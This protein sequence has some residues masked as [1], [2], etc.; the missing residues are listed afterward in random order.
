MNRRDLLK[1]IAASAASPYVAG[2]AKATPGLDQLSV[3]PVHAF[4][5]RPLKLSPGS[6]TSDRLF[7]VSGFGDVSASRL[8]RL[9]AWAEEAPDAECHVVKMYNQAG[10]GFD[11]RMVEP[12]FAM[13]VVEP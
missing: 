10:P 2:V 1:M 7:N 12:G 9:R 6:P 13:P 11:M 8:E 3:R 5:T 4:S